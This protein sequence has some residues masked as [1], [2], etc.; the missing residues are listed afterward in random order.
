MTNNK[1]DSVKII[2]DELCGEEYRVLSDFLRLVGVFVCNETFQDI[3]LDGDKFDLI[4]YIENEKSSVEIK[5][6]IRDTYGTKLCEIHTNSI[7]K[8][9]AESDRVAYRKAVLEYVFDHIMNSSHY[10]MGMDIGVWKVL[11]ASFLKHDFV[12]ARTFVY[13]RN[14]I[15][16]AEEAQKDFAKIIVAIS[17][18]YNKLPQEFQH[19]RY[20][21]YAYL[22]LAYLINETCC[23]LRQDF[24]FDN[25]K[26]YDIMEMSAI[27]YNDFENYYLLMAFLAELDSTLSLKA[28]R[29][30]QIAA[31]RLKNASFAN[32]AYY[33]FGRYCEIELKNEKMARDYYNRAYNVNK[34][35]YR[36]IYKLG[37]YALKDKHYEEAAFCFR[38]IQRLL[39]GKFK[40]NALQEKEYEYYF[41][42]CKILERI[43]LILGNSAMV[44]ENAQKAEEVLEKTAGTKKNPI[45]EVLFGDTWK[46]RLVKTHE[47]LSGKEMVKSLFKVQNV[48]NA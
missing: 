33:R 34:K 45:Y 7:R 27:K 21:D 31:S 17:E 28:E 29:C 47:R 41:K 1:I 11:A 36:A 40:A 15:P 10:V 12:K 38:R 44:R 19:S 23:Y 26:L 9:T 2:H 30:Y 8:K 37:Y 13:F 5:T 25:R 43:G 39:E 24:Y 42:S 6:K 32:Y 35:E 22:Q 14:E 16:Y 18:I 46:E 3:Q 4:I 20:I 48:L